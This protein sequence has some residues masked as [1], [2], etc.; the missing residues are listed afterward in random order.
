MKV[1]ESA[2]CNRILICGLRSS[3]FEDNV[4]VVCDAV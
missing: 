4:F 3:D 1:V 2:I